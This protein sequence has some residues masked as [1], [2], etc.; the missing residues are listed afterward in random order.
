MAKLVKTGGERGA[1]QF[2]ASVS[3][4]VCVSVCK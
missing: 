1:F 2:T 4:C 3:V